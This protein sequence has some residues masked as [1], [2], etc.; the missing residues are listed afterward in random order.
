MDCQARR[1]PATKNLSNRDWNR[2]ATTAAFTLVELLVVIAIIGILVALLLPAVQAAREAARRAQCV[3]NEK[4]HVL[5]FLQYED[6][7]KELPP[8]RMGC[9]GGG[10]TGKPAGV[11]DASLNNLEVPISGFF[12][13]LPNIEQQALYD[14]LP[15][16]TPFPNETLKFNPEEDQIKLT[17]RNWFILPANQQLIRTPVDA[18]RCPSDLSQPLYTHLG[19]TSTFATGSYA[20]C[21]GSKGPQPSEGYGSNGANI[22][23]KNTGAFLYPGKQRKLKRIT[24]GLSNTFFVGEA[25]GGDQLDSRNRWILGSRY[26][27]SMRTTSYPLNSLPE[28]YKETSPSTSY[29]TNGAF[30]STH[31]SG[32]NFGFGDG[33]VEF[34]TDEI[35][36]A[37]YQALSTIA[38]DPVITEPTDLTR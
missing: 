10:D 33:H 7:K 36:I 8:G 11:C 18:Y 34:I 29:V 12:A 22:K 24:D 6:Q 4:Q 35:G 15:I 30:R 13:I 28:Q 2:R 20:M 5:A 1:W 26:I 14:Q 17:G 9:D 3:N 23:W 19:E 37:V 21:M 31:P 16:E 38:G 27:D 32:A 25:S